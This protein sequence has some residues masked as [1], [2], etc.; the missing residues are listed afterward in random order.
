MPPRTRPRRRDVRF[1]AARTFA[2]ALLTAA[3]VPGGAA[4]AQGRAPTPGA[5]LAH[6]CNPV[7]VS[8]CGLP[9][10]SDMFTVADRRSPT[11]RRIDVDDA[12]VTASYTSQVPRSTSPSRVLDGATGFSAS[13][14]VLF[15]LDGAPDPASLPADGGDALVAYDTTTG[16]RVAV[17]VEVDAEAA[18]TTQP[19]AGVRAWPAVRFDHAHH[20]VVALTSALH[21]RDGSPYTPSR[22]F[23]AVLTGSPSPV[24]THYAP[25]LA[26][27]AAHG[28]APETLV[29]ATDFTVRDEHD[30]QSRMLAPVAKATARPH[31]V[32]IDR[33]E[34]TG[35][36]ASSL[37]VYGHVALTS[38]QDRGDG[39]F[40]AFGAG[41]PYRTTFQLVVPASAATAPAPVAIF[42]HGYGGNKTRMVEFLADNDSAGIATLAIDWSNRGTRTL[43]DGGYV[44]SLDQPPEQ[45]RFVS[46][47]QQGVVDVAS[48]RRAVATSLAVLD[49]QPSG[50]DGV[51]DLDADHVMYEGTSYGGL[52]GATALAAVGGL[53]GGI[54]HVCGLG[55]MDIFVRLPVWPLQKGL[56]PRDGPGT[57]A[58]VGVALLQHAVDP[59]EPANWAHRYRTPPG[60]GLSRPVLLQYGEGDAWVP[61]A[62]S[63]ALIDVAGLPEVVAPLPE[64]GSPFGDGY[65]RQMVTN[66]QGVPEWAWPMYAHAFATTQPEARAVTSAW[67]AE[68]RGG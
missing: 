67:L 31:G 32:R 20:Y 5:S 21:R 48:L 53:D 49:V 33:V 11:G 16:D 55:L 61:N 13:T 65:G 64:T 66:T 60:G 40:R 37:T 41:R 12:L 23:A 25:V 63:R 27:L 51:P 36:P 50:G 44:L 22:G 57:D 59:A 68:Y 39:A 58:A 9:F 24:T 56:I 52:L 38:F 6:P 43:K 15:E 19:S 47:F 45:A 28:V 2:V 8:A 29:S 35:K 7:S 62:S 17:R 1:A 10:P 14:P 26:F 18:G 54:L 30:V 34:A 42:G 3:T 46:M 4:A